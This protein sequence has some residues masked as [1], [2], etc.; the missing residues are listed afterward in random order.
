M[1]VL[2]FILFASVLMSFETQACA[3][4]SVLD[5]PIFIT[6]SLELLPMHIKHTSW[7]PKLDERDAEPLV[8]ALSILG[9]DV[10][11]GELGMTDAKQKEA[12]FVALVS[13]LTPRKIILWGY[14]IRLMRVQAAIN[15]AAASMKS[16]TD[17]DEVADLRLYR[18]IAGGRYEAALQCVLKYSQNPDIGTTL[19]T[20]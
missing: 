18:A 7:F 4:S 10:F 11:S 20:P 19:G 13:G 5:E 9:A 14:T 12:V 17:A 3:Q 2:K 6:R 1:R 15:Q 8:E 16:A